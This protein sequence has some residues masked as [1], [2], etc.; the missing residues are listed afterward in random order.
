MMTTSL[1]SCYNPNR[2]SALARVISI[3]LVGLATRG[4]HQAHYS[5]PANYT[6]MS[7]VGY[8]R[9]RYQKSLLATFNYSTTRAWPYMSK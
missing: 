3:V 4:V 5:C 2:I 1:I 7:L 9:M 6:N 8:I